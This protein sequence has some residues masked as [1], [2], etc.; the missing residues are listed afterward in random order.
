MRIAGLRG[1]STIS[2]QLVKN[3][4]LTTHRSPIRK[5]LELTLVPI[6][7][8]V[9]SKDRILELYLNH[10]E[11]GRGIWG[12]EAASRHYYGISVNRLDREQGAR[13]AACIPDPRRRRPSQ[14]G[15]YSGIILERMRSRGW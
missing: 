4:F 5:G 1:G 12:V 15:A 3:L 14:M 2:Q 11:W 8:L 9:L 10:I 6:A 7:E 13:L